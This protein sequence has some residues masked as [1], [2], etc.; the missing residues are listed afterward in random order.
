MFKIMIFIL[1]ALVIL[2]GCGRVDEEQTQDNATYD[3]PTFP[4][5]NCTADTPTNDYGCY[6]NKVTFHNEVVVDGIWNIYTQSNENR[7]DGVVFY[8]RY[9]YGYEFE[10]NDGTAGKQEKTDGYT[11]YREWGVNDSGDRIFVGSHSS[12][13]EGEYTYNGEIFSDGCLVVT[14][15]GETLKMCHESFV[16]TTYANSTGYYGLNVR[17]GNRT[18]YDFTAAGTW[19]ILGYGDNTDTKPDEVLYTNGSTGSEGV[20]GVSKDGKVIGIN[21]VRYLVYQYLD[22]SE[23]NCIAVFELSGGEVTSIKWKLCKQ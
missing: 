3:D 12:N 9:Q 7:T 5:V 19:S 4:V 13:D 14:N 15:S 10:G 22:G 17:F 18:G 8:D 21:G 11:L 23:D 16:D 20:W 2:A 6:S 1:W